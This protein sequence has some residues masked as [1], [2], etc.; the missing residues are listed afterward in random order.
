MQSAAPKKQATL[1]SMFAKRSPTKTTEV[2][3][4]DEDSQLAGGK[5]PRSRSGSKEKRKSPSPPKR[6]GGNG[7]LGDLITE[8]SWR[9]EL[10]PVLQDAAQGKGLLSQIEKFIDTAEGKGATVLPPRPCIFTAFN[11]TPFDKVKVVLLGQD[12]YHDIGQAHGLCF[13]VQP[14][15]RPPPSLKNMYKELE[16]DVPG[17]TT[18]SHGYLQSWA[19]QGIL[20]LNATLTVTAHE[21]NSHAKCGW[22]QFTDEV[23]VRVSAQRERRVVFLLWGNFARGKRS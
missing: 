4:V 1:E 11:R 3:S 7:W 22:Q 18:P 6:S 19:D 16:S 15:V 20:M 12:P 9:K 5:R 13:S 21:A 17:F 2:I 14:G 8:P 23:I 10:Q